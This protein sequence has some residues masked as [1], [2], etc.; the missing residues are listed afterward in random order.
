MTNAEPGLLRVGASFLKAAQDR[1]EAG[2]PGW[3]PNLSGTP[4]LHATGRLLG[5]LT[6]GGSGS[7]VESDDRHITV[8]SNVQVN[9][10]NLGALMQY[11]TGI[12]GSRGTPIVPTSK[13]ALAFTIRGKHVFATSVKGAPKRPF[14]YLDQQNATVATDILRR[15][16]LIG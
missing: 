10:Y 3:A 5:S 7:V 2:G 16:F 1:I 4:L 14:L 6:V 15:Y 12:Y 9:G 8:G 13:K 11:G